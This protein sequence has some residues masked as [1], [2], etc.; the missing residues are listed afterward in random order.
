VHFLS[1]KVGEAE[2]GTFVSYLS[3]AMVVPGMPLQMVF[4]HQTAKALAT[5]RE[6]E[7]TGMIRMMWSGSLVLWMF[8]CIVVWVGQKGIMQAWGLA[9]ASGL[10]MT[11]GVVL[12]SLWL[13][14]LLGVLQ[15]KQDFFWMGWS[16]MS[17]GMGRVTLAF[18]AVTLVSATAASMMF[19][20]VA[21][22]AI[23]T[24]IAAWFARSL[25]RG[26]SSRF[27]WRNLLKEVIPPML[28][29]G[30]FQFLFTADTMFV[31][32]YFSPDEV[33]FYGGA[34]TLSRALMWLVT[35]LAAVM[36]P[37]IVHSA[38]K[39]EKTDLMGIVMIGTAV[40]AIL[41]AICLSI[42][43]P[44][45]VRMVYRPNWVQPV[46][47][48]LPWYA[49]AMVPMALANVL[50]NNLLG[51]SDFRIVPP[52]CILAIGYA[53]ALTRFHDSLI[54][55]L[56]TIG[57]AGIV[58]LIISAWFTWGSKARTLTPVQTTS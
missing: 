5:N 7:L 51:R 49:G 8:G 44:I 28:G 11:V 6:R 24:G 50:L 27:D 30:A 52:L 29:F 10:W 57:L 40:L 55:V 46:A 32:S 56:K 34:G 54:T 35:P 20:A 25:W 39:A 21:G 41:G 38:A 37:K 9:N 3:I 31:K 17:N 13:P 26:P 18:V 58:L 16:M 33:G 4:A 22:M 12:F 23:A 43:G 36:F 42:V 45:V 47:A 48:I 15:G 53:F 19:G 1:K 14:M 2:Y